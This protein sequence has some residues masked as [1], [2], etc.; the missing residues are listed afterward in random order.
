MKRTL[1]EKF[2][3]LI[4]LINKTPV[5]NSIRLNGASLVLPPSSLLWRCRIKCLGERNRIVIEPECILRNC[6]VYIS[7]NDNN[8]FIRRGVHARS[9]EFWIED[10]GNSVRVGSESNLCGRAHLAC[11]EG[12]AI[13]IGERCLFSSDLVF[14]TGD[15]HSIIDLETGYRLNHAADIRIGN[16]VW[17]GHHVLV[18]KGVQIADSCVVG[19][20][21]VLVKGVDES[22][23]VIAGV[24]A[25]VIR[26]NIRWDS[27]RI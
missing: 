13:E 10:D 12:S 17:I 25:K 18:N 7:G 6:R 15:S 4:P 9:V 2:R 16:H 23:C 24:P 21:S 3:F 27:G 19:T 8:I 14:R 26:K 20:G 22:N 11:T 1:K 5:M